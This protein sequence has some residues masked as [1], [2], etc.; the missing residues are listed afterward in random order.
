[1]DEMNLFAFQLI[2]K[3]GDS[4]S[5]MMEGLEIAKAGNIVEA[6]KLMK[7]AKDTLNEAHKIH[8]ELLV[9]EA[10]GETI[11]YS[12]ILVHAQD[13]MTKASLADIF[14]NEQINLYQIIFEMKEGK[15]V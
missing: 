13:H 8:T 14:I 15:V 11:T 6:K 12:P 5:M 10:Q 3:A 1:M 4:F 9:K 2:S 7:D